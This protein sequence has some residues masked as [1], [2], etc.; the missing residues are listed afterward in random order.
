LG[1]EEPL[2]LASHF[3]VSWLGTPVPPEIQASIVAMGPGRIRRAWLVPLFEAVLMPTEPDDNPTF[4]QE[5]AAFVVLA[6]YHRQRMPM[7]LL[8][9][10]LWHKLRTNRIAQTDEVAKP[11]QG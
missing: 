2:A 9:P 11:A 6:R 1:L 8:V 4:K 5:I 10:H 7:R 3:C